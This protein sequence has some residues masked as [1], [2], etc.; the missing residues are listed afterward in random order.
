[1]KYS[2]TER[3]HRASKVSTGKKALLAS[4]IMLASVASQAQTD[5]SG[6]YWG[7]TGGAGFNQSD[8]GEL[9]FSRADGS[10]NSAA[11][12]R[13]FGGSFDGKFEAGSVLG[14]RAGMNWQS[15]SFVYGVLA[16]ISAADLAE[17]QSAFSA[18][19]A[20]YIERR[21]IESLATLR[22]K[23]GLAN[24]SIALP[25]FTAGVAY[26]DVEYSW[27][28]NS[29]AFR[30][31]NGEDGD[32][33]GLVVG[34]GV[35]LQLSDSTRLGVEYLHHDLGDADFQTR[36]SGEAGGALAAFGNAASGGTIARGTEEDFTF[37]TLQVNL[38]W[39]F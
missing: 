15:G 18:T 9:R 29:G 31:D 20:T 24:D 38:N 22:A 28:G 3:T 14:L 13:A 27:E 10:D 1:M 35:D 33:S 21:E 11:I 8:S 25:Y 16:D 5:W 37:Q 36:F 19:P 2:D 6:G 23:L 4:S 26:G 12:G 17:E 7:L 34:V 39:A 30:G 32:G